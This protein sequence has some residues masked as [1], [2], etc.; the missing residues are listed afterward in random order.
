MP[1]GPEPFTPA[2]IGRLLH[3]ALNQ[4][5][6]P[7]ERAWARARLIEEKPRIA[8]DA[9]ALAVKQVAAAKLHRDADLKKIVEEIFGAG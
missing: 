2:L 1:P 9:L 4:G 7:Q 6:K 8:P 3:L 5:I